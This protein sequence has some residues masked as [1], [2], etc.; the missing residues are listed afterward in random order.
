MAGGLS[1]Q[2]FNFTGGKN[3]ES[4]K[5]NYSPNTAQELINFTLDG[6]GTVSRRLGLDKE[7][8]GTTPIT[9]A[10]ASMLGY[11]SSM[12]EW[13]GAGGS[14]DRVV[15]VAH[16]G[17]TLYFFDG[18]QDALS[19][20]YMTSLSLASYSVASSYSGEPLS[21]SSGL[22]YLFVSGQHVHPLYVKLNDDDT[23]TATRISVKIRDFTG[24]DD[25]LGV[26]ERP[27][28]LSSAH[29]YNLRNQ[30]WPV[31]FSTTNLSDPIA[32]TR[33][34]ID[35]YPSNADVIHSALVD[36]A[37][38]ADLIGIYNPDILEKNVFGNTPA[39]KGHFILDA[40][41]LN[42]SSA[43]GF[44]VPSSS[45][46]EATISSRPAACCFFYGRLFM[47]GLTDSGHTGKVFVSKLANSIADVGVCHQDADPTAEDI[48]ALVSTDGLVLKLH[49]CAAIRA[50]KVIGNSLVVIATNG[51]WSIRGGSD[52]GFT[53]EAYIV[54]K[55]SDAGT[56]YTGS[57]VQTDGGVFYWSD[58]GIY[59]CVPDQATGEL[60]VKNI[61]L[62]TIHTDYLAIPETAKRVA[63]S[64]YDYIDSKVYWLY[65][66]VGDALAE[67]TEVSRYDRMLVLD[68]RLSAFYDIHV[69]DLATASPF[70]MGMCRSSAVSAAGTGSTGQLVDNSGN[71]I[72]VTES[73]S[74]TQTF[75][76]D[77]NLL[78]TGANLVGTGVTVSGFNTNDTLTIRYPGGLLYDAMEFTSGAGAWTTHAFWYIDDTTPSGQPEFRIGYIASQPTAAQALAAVQALGDITV[79]GGGES[80]T[81]WLS[82]FDPANNSGGVSFSVYKNSATY[83][84]YNVVVNTAPAYTSTTST[85]KLLTAFPDGT[86][87][88]ISFSEFSNTDFLDWYSHDSV[89]IDCP[90]SIITGY[91]VGVGA[92][93]DGEVRSGARR[94]QANYI[95]M[96]FNQTETA[97][98]SIG[99][100]LVFDRP[101]SC[102]LRARWDFSN[103]SAWGKWSDY[104]EVYRLTRMFIANA[105]GA[106]AY[107]RGVITTRNKLRGSGKAL[108]LQM[109]TTAG[110][111]M[112]LLGW[113]AQYGISSKF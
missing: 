63:I 8:S 66:S 75:M 92:T 36:T 48:N 22:G 13:R 28:T 96:H 51:V 56:N 21:M 74:P 91:D 15:Q 83:T 3:T 112:Q 98:E 101:S 97:L 64:F 35:V 34:R 39:P 100:G 81:F 30:G 32:E 111:D 113:E 99:A 90:G 57:V 11:A 77:V 19:T 42:R 62:E 45:N 7:T 110:H 37:T 67:G 78:G 26:D 109:A 1:K 52:T 104:W 6:S 54:D 88:D 76:Q 5:F 4:G 47:G 94:K 38:D 106:F 44:T 80:Y 27:A 2:M 16:I 10:S 23:V 68:M 79:D 108:Q 18:D 84:D 85:L 53:A 82:D 59:A 103:T 107:G 40:F 14:A 71:T 20:G 41:S 33:R 69:Y 12:F 55:L 58:R 89:G 70:V 95:V 73:A 93:D 61:S 65:N 102:Q 86:D 105:A 46:F 31:T 25:G 60:S 9:I 24:V 17:T 29:K 50:I 72:I 87:N 49:E 43:A